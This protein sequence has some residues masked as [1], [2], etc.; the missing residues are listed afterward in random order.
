VKKEFDGKAIASDVA[1]SRKQYRMR[2]VAQALIGAFGL[3]RPTPLRT[4]FT[5]ALDPV[6]EIRTKWGAFKCRAGH[7]RLVWRAETFF[8]E[9]PQTVEWLDRMGP[10]DVLWDVGANVGM[11]TLYAAALRKCRVVSFEPEAQNY[12]LLIDNIAL[13]GIEDLCLPANLALS[14]GHRIGRLRVRYVTKGGAYNTFLARV[15]AGPGEKLPESFASAQGYEAHR[16]IEQIMA[17]YSIDELVAKHGLPAPTHLKI[18]VDGIEPEIVEGARAVLASGSVRSVLIE[19]NRKSPA[20]MAIPGILEGYGYR[21]TASRSN[22]DS[23]A[24][25]AFAA[26]TPTENMIFDLAN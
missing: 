18:D 6:S 23:R 21:L 24:D 15:S 14:D 9:E 25:K 19:I 13:N 20:D 7:G 4:E 11:Y 22:W 5:Q 16:G 8:S 10:G 2:K 26:E 17:S 3:N 12:A 1:R